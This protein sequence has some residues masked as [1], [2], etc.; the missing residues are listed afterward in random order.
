VASYY[1]MPG[2]GE[3]V[4]GVVD[5]VM[6]MIRNRVGERS[7]VNVVRARAQFE[8][9]YPAI[10]MIDG[11]TNT[12]WAGE[13]SQNGRW[14]LDFF[15]QE[16][17]DLLQV[18]IDAGADGETFD[19]LARPKEIQIRANQ[20]LSP[21]YTLADTSEQQPIEIDLQDVKELRIIVHSAY[22]GLK[23]DDVIAVREVSFVGPKD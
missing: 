21:R 14:Q 12:W 8:P 18:N 7:E 3:Q 17:S 22:V 1:F 10:N 23:S 4:E 20:E 2:V 15:L 19:Q 6:R 13:V 11:G 16:P 5:D 9:G